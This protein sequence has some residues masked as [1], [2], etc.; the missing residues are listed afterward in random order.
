MALFDSRAVRRLPRQP[1]RGLLLSIVVFAGACGL[2][3]IGSGSSPPTTLPATR[4][5][6]A[7]GQGLLAPEI[8]LP[9]AVADTRQRIATAA[10]SC[11]FAALAAIAEPVVS[12]GSGRNTAAYWRL[13]EA[14]GREPMRT[15]LAL[16]NTTPATV[17]EQHVWPAAYARPTFDEVTPQERDDLRGLYDERELVDF[18]RLGTYAGWRIGI[19]GDGTWTFFT[20]GD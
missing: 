18:E 6:S 2:G 14:A 17:D 10:R 11:D 16:L 12:I 9:D 15:L 7:S 13:E 3:G 1:V 5:C 19:R 20:A 8:G 4:P